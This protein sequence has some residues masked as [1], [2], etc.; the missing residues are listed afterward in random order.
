MVQKMGHYSG[1]GGGVWSIIVLAFGWSSQVLLRCHRWGMVSGEMNEH[2]LH[3][4]FL[5]Y[6]ACSE[7][8]DG[9]DREYF[10]NPRVEASLSLSRFLKLV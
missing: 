8:A 4:I 1:W 7:I 10:E 3:I 6:D 5:A 9:L 2:R